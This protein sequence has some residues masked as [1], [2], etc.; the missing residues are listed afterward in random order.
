MSVCAVL[1]TRGPVVAGAIL[2]PFEQASREGVSLELQGMQR[3][4]DAL[5]EADDGAMTFNARRVKV[6]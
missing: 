2:A 5:P 3:V 6:L 4:Q 1:T